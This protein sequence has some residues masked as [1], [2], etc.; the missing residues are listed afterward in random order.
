M[1][2]ATLDRKFIWDI[3]FVKRKGWNLNFNTIFEFSWRFHKK[4]NQYFFLQYYN[5]YGESL[6]DYNQFHSRLRA[7]IVIKPKFFSEF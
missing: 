6:L 5:G 4:S 7:G 3:T 2:I 1:E